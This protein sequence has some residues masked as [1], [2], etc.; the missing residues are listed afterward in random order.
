[1]SVLEGYA[2]DPSELFK[3]AEAVSGVSE[4]AINEAYAALT[5]GCFTFPPPA[6]QSPSA[7]PPGRT[8]ESPI[9]D[10]D[11]Y[12]ELGQI[13]VEWVNMRL[14]IISPEGIHSQL[15]ENDLIRFQI[16][17]ENGYLRVAEH[18]VKYRA[19]FQQAGA[20]MAKLMDALTQRFASYG[21]GKGINIDL[22]SFLLT[23]LVEV[24]CAVITGGLSTVF[25]VKTIAEVATQMVG[26]AGKTAKDNG[27]ETSNPIDDHPLIVDTVK[28]YLDAMAKIERDTA[29]A[30][31]GLSLHLH[32]K[33]VQL[34]QDRRYVNRLTE[35]NSNMAPQFLDYAQGWR[36]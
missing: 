28:Q 24:A 33:V 29:S 15:F 9:R 35:V 21:Q 4:T 20:D 16:Y 2:A 8:P 13:R 1:M 34:E 18:L 32:T 10:G 26:D 31:S 7:P 6:T 3:A 17:V 11:M 25:K 27:Q 5:Q 12:G 30:I 19:I 14:S 36:A 23:G 22:R